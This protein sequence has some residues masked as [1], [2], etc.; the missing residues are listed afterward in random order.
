MWLI[1][2]IVFGRPSGTDV[3]QAT[4]CQTSARLC[5]LSSLSRKDA[6]VLRRSRIGHTLSKQC[7]V[8]SALAEAIRSW[9][10]G[11]LRVATVSGLKKKSSSR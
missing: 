11:T 6:V 2:V 7:P 4:L 8:K 5:N 10:D 3:S 1:T 9:V